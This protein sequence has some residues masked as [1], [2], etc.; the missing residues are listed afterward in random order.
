MYVISVL[1]LDSLFLSSLVHFRSILVFN[2][3]PILGHF[4]PTQIHFQSI[5]GK[6]SVLDY[7]AREN[8]KVSYVLVK[9]SEGPNQNRKWH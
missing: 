4:L 5:F 7:L 9:R 8:C 6:V 1:F 3:W 2:K